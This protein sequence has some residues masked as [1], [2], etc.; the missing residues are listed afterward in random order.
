MRE[1][2]PLN[3]CRLPKLAGLCGLAAVALFAFLCLAP[4]AR[5]QAQGIPGL[6]IPAPQGLDR[7]FREVQF[8]RGD[9][10]TDRSVDISDAIAT[11]VWLF[12]GGQESTCT[13]AGDTNG[14]SAVDLSD[15]VFTLAYLFRA[16]A[17]PAAP[18]PF[19]CGLAPEPGKLSCESYPGCSNDL[20][21]IT[22][23]LNR[24]TFGPTEE[25]LT[26][27][28][29][30]EDLLAYIEEQL[31]PP[32]NFDQAADEPGLAAIAESL[33]LGFNAD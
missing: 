13:I 4:C 12:A 14:D 6:D 26:R 9:F 29:T 1:A 16:G 8:R 15:G 25:L 21:L 7:Y 22:H 31:N 28:Q 5:T 2:D 17:E 30:R 3:T 18:G 23:V 11:F 20:P 10:N 24:I 33:E 32:G 27:I 19:E